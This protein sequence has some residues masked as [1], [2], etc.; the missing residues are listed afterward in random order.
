[1]KER[2]ANALEQFVKAVEKALNALGLE[3]VPST[4]TDALR[5]AREE[6]IDALACDCEEDKS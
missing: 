4:A 1:M 2:T 3:K 5:D 6:L